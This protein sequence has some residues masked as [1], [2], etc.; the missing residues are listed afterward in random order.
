MDTQE[1]S[2]RLGV[3]MAAARKRLEMSQSAAA[4]AAKVSRPTWNKWEKDKA[5]PEDYNHIK[6]ERTLAWTPG[7]VRV[8][9]D[10]GEPT[11]TEPSAEPDGSATSEP[12]GFVNI[13]AHALILYR[14]WRDE[15]DEAFI[16]AGSELAKKLQDDAAIRKIYRRV[17]ELAEEAH[18]DVHI[19]DAR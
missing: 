19:K 14:K 15:G 12:S 11:T 9:F 4:R 3:R 16:D 8:I 17:N 6:I 18:G 5:T 10:G 1:P 2:P 7:D 13:E